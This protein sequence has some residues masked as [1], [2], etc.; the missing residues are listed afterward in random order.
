MPHDRT[1]LAPTLRRAFGSVTPPQKITQEAHEGNPKHL[2]RLA[3]LRHGDLAEVSDLW[4]YMQDLLYTDIQGPLLAYLLPFCL[5]G[6]RQDLRGTRSEYGGFVE[7]FYP[8]LAN[9]QV[10]NRH[11]TAAQGAAV[12]TFMR[13]SILDE[14]EDQQGLTYTGSGTR[15]YR[16]ITALTTHGVLLPDVD[17]L[18]GAWWSVATIGRA[19]ALAQYVSC[20]MYPQNENPVFAPW[21]PERGGGPPCLWEFAGHLYTNRW[22]EEN[23]RFLKQ[24]LSPQAVTEVLAR[25][26]NR[27][28]GQPEHGVAV[29]LQSDLPLC[30]ETL[31]A[32][33]AELPNVLEKTREPER[34]REW[35]S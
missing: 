29:E 5:E 25:A 6:W 3:R 4:K 19:I 7:Y 35:S 20:L 34:V 8:V 9:R 15:P 10:F 13:E 1:G 27:L 21:T 18:W 33:C 26:V 12:S 24:T 23:V 11:L 28:V 17:T 30:A 32:R 31:A 2:F 14:M 16:W 22:R